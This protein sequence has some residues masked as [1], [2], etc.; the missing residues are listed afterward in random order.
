M[1]M[2]DKPLSDSE[3]SKLKGAADKLIV[4]LDENPNK[5][6]VSM[7]DACGLKCC[8]FCPLV[9]CGIPACLARDRYLKVMKN[10][11]EDYSC[12]QGACGNSSCVPECKGSKLGLCCEGLCCPVLSLSITR[13]YIMGERRL[14]PDPTDYQ[15]RE[16]VRPRAALL[17]N[18]VP[19]TLLTSR[20][21][22]PCS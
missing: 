7:K 13:A 9:Y 11:I 4:N 15:V 1:C 2:D 12:C 14:Q 6:V 10:G 16:F 8:L 22:P 17:R 5:P 18:R 19:N 21:S 3:K 20:S